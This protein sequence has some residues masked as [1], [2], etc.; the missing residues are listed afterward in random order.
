MEF[1]DYQKLANRTLLGNEQ[2][3]TN[4]ALG[5]ASESGEVIDLIK[6][7]TFNGE[8]LKR[9]ELVKKMG[10][11]LWYLSQVA[12]WANIPFEE[13]AQQNITTL[14]TRYGKQIDAQKQ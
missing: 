7:Y 14:N 5:L 3:L 1:N 12:E 2:V 10:D 13:V 4:C 8:D 11:V 6:K 9:D